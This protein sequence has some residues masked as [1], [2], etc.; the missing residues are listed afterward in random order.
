M[1]AGKNLETTGPL[2]SLIDETCTCRYYSSLALAQLRTRIALDLV[3][4]LFQK[5][6]DKVSHDILMAK[7][8]AHG[9]QRDAAKWIQ[10]GFLDVANGYALTNRTAT[11]NLSHLVYH[12]YCILTPLLFLLYVNDIDANIVS[13]FCTRV[14]NLD[15]LMELMSGQ[16]NDEIISMYINVP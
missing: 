12:K 10:N 7:F 14:R 13:K 5:T 15:D 16:T 9:I 11:G 1:E 6:F 3:Y 2:V 4:M 8:D